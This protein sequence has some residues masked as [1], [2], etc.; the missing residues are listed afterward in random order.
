MIP[1]SIGYTRGATFG[2]K[3]RTEIIPAAGQIHESVWYNYQV[4]V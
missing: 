1:C 3:Y 2:A 4:T